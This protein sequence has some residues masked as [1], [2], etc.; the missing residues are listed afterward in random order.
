MSQ[1]DCTINQ[2]FHYGLTCM[3]M[4]VKSSSRKGYDQMLQL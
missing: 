1:S 4:N 2:L 3:Y